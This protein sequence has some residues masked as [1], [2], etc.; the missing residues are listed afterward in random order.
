MTLAQEFNNKFPEAVVTIKRTSE[1][2]DIVY[3]NGQTAFNKSDRSWYSDYM[4]RMENALKRS[5]NN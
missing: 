3:V 1:G 4:L 2:D 5:I